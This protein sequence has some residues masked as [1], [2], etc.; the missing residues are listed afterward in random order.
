MRN[1]VVSGKKHVDHDALR[2][3]EHIK[4]CYDSLEDK[5]YI[6]G[7]DRD[8]LTKFFHITRSLDPE[9]LFFV[10][11]VEITRIMSMDI[12]SSID[13][14]KLV[15]V[16]HDAYILSSTLSGTD[17]SFDVVGRMASGSVLAAAWNPDRTLLAIIE[18]NN[19][20]S[21]LSESF[22]LVRESKVI[23][24]DE[25]RSGELVSVGWGKKETQFHG[26]VGKQAALKRDT[27]DERLLSSDDGS[28]QIVWHPDGPFFACSVVFEGNFGLTRKIYVYE[29]TGD[30]YSISEPITGLEGSALAWKPNGELIAAVQKVEDK[31]RVIFFERNGLR[32]GEFDIHDTPV[33]SLSWNSDSSILAVHYSHPEPMLHGKLQL[34]TM[35]NYHYY[36]KQE[37][38]GVHDDAIGWAHFHYDD[39]RILHIKHNGHLFAYHI[40]WSIDSHDGTVCVIDGKKVLLTP[41]RMANIPPPMS[42][43]EISFT[44]PVNQVS[45]FNHDDYYQ[46]SV[47]LSGGDIVTMDIE[48][49]LDGVKILKEKLYKGPYMQTVY[50]ADDCYA[51]Q[52][53]LTEMGRDVL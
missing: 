20:L 1:L 45:I 13:G 15:L 10:S 9:Q 31:R 35:C 18:S 17:L 19:A 3:L 12:V 33:H 49:T 44:E 27:F 22:D 36:L 21:I 4:A 2:D 6:C 47:L 23:M 30:C 26:S 37:F 42:V 52:K 24:E 38:L 14:E 5:T 40:D 41:F 16:T 43:G 39:P 8:A 48:I 46:L 32:H 11:Q 53:S 25:G 34:W 29:Q 50:L 51:L 28:A 7:H